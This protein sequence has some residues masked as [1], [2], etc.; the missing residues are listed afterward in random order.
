MLCDVLCCV[1]WCGV[2][3]F[4]SQLSSFSFLL[5]SLF[6][7]LF[8]LCSLLASKHYG[9]NRST[10]TAANIEAFECDLA[11]GKCTAV[12]LSLLSSPLLL[13]KK[14]N[15]LLQKYFRRGSYFTLQFHLNSEK[16]TSTTIKLQRV[17]S[18]NI[19]AEMVY[20]R[21]RSLSICGRARNRLTIRTSNHQSLS[22]KRSIASVQWIQREREKSN[23]RK[24][25]V[26]LAARH[27]ALV[28]RERLICVPSITNYF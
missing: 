5:S 18:V 10:N 11:Q 1:V 19:F 13:T 15:F 2:F 27:H 9:K 20:V 21:T 8:L 25:N 6:S 17:K 28:E 3:S 16:S 26:W 23:I 24:S 4:F 12:V 14:R 7:P 22:T